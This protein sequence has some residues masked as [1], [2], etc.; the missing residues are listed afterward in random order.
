M[1]F[2]LSRTNRT[3]E[4]KSLPDHPLFRHLFIA[5]AAGLALSTAAVQAQPQPA[6]PSKPIT[7]IVGYPPGGGMDSFC[8]QVTALVSVRLG[9]PMVVQNR[10]GADGNIGLTAVARSA[11]DGYTLSCVPHSMTQSPHTAALPIDILKDLTPIAMLTRWQFTLFV[12]ADHPAKTLNELIA[13]AKARTGEVSHGT[14]GAASRLTAALLE[15]RAGIRFMIV[16]FPGTAPVQTALVG[17]HIDSTMGDTTFAVLKAPDGQPARVRALVVMA[18]KRDPGLPGVPA[19]TEIYPDLDPAAWYGLI[20]P[21]GMP[22]DV[23]ERVNAEFNAVMNS[24]PL[25]QKFAERGWHS[26]TGSAA[27][28]AKTVR[29]DYARY[30]AVIKEFGIGV[31]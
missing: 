7:V 24:S 12:R 9:Q 19:I 25:R 15:S 2:K 28:F 6:Y 8:R 1:P 4:G 10:P 11:P 29:D 21:G 5:L 3:L 23:V 20:G 16:P 17:G 30:G 27:E 26:S 31:K 18:S 14:A 13:M 22:A